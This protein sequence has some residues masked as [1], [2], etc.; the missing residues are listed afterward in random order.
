MRHARFTYSPIISFLGKFITLNDYQYSR[1]SC[2]VLAQQ[3]LM[4]M[5]EE[6]DL[7]KKSGHL[8]QEI[9]Y[10]CYRKQRS[11]FTFSPHLHFF[12]QFTVFCLYS[13]RRVYKTDKITSFCLKSHEES[14]S[15]TNTN[16]QCE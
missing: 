13:S 11:I 4:L 9:I 6:C 3:N 14:M 5:W 2:H 8:P 15:I 10:H 1:A 7:S 12:L 16:L